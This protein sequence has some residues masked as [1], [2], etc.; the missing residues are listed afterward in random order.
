[1]KTCKYC[2]TERPDESFEVC[3]VVAGKTYRRLKCQQCKQVGR[4]LRRNR[5]RHWLDEYK[6]GLACERCGFADYRA[7]DFHHSRGD[8]QF[9]VADM[10]RYG[11][12]IQTIRKE[13]GKCHVLCSNCHRI[14]HHK[15]RNGA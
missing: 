14:E 15:K 11:S 8:K 9:N 3:R 10:L 13:I 7:L 1:M 2:N 6:K 4:A 12:S 5:I